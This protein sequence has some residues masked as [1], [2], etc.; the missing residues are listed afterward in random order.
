MNAQIQMTL[1]E[2]EDPI[3][4]GG[5]YIF[6]GRRTEENC[7]VKVRAFK[8]SEM[9]KRARPGSKGPGLIL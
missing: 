1:N 5:L 3:W 7:W 6:L 4:S 2:L 8:G 9:L